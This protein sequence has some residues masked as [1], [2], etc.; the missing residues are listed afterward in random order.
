M[1]AVQLRSRARYV[2]GWK[3]V[4]CRCGE[5]GKSDLTL[6]LSARSRRRVTKLERLERALERVGFCSDGRAVGGGS[7]SERWLQS[8]SSLL[9]INQSLAPHRTG[10]VAPAGHHSGHRDTAKACPD[11]ANEQWTDLQSAWRSG[12]AGWNAECLGRDQAQQHKVTTETLRESGERWR[13][14]DDQPEPNHH[15][16]RLYTRSLLTSYRP[17]G[18]TAR[19]PH[20]RAARTSACTPCLVRNWKRGGGAPSYARGQMTPLQCEREPGQRS[21][22]HG[23][24]SSWES[25]SA[26]ASPRCRRRAGGAS[27]SDNQSVNEWHGIHGGWL[28]LGPVGIGPAGIRQATNLAAGRRGEETRDMHQSARPDMSPPVTRSA[29]LLQRRQ[30]TGGCPAVSIL[31]SQRWRVGAAVVSSPSQGSNP[32]LRVDRAGPGRGRLTGAA[33]EIQH[34]AG[35]L[36]ARALLQRRRVLDWCAGRRTRNREA[37]EPPC[38]GDRAPTSSQLPSRNGSVP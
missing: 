32:R 20:H 9:A 36:G 15:A 1:A 12:R 6:L 7:E 14:D 19:L 23:M 4:V 26:I 17:Q 5:N 33:C 8:A 34:L 10:L 22:W 27:E 31:P 21:R 24:A 2:P 25:G 30:G 13:E 29:A 18:Q 37:M 28:A 3:N 38:Q 11:V 16:A 35:W